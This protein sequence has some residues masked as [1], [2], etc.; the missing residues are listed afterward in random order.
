[1]GLLVHQ[2]SVFRGSSQNSGCIAQRASPGISDETQDI[3]QEHPVHE[4]LV[5]RVIRNDVE[6]ADLPGWPSGGLD[7]ASCLDL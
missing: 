3:C 4:G 6:L 2:T 5:V 1:M 7:L